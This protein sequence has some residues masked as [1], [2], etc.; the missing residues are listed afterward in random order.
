M[1]L[2]TA[3][4]ARF[5]L[6]A[7]F[8]LSKG[9]IQMKRFLLIL[10]SAIP[11]SALGLLLYC[12]ETYNDAVHNES[13]FFICC[14]C[15]LGLIISTILWCCIRKRIGP[16]TVIWIISTIILVFVFY[17]GWKIPFCVVCDRVTAEDLG[18][19]I[20]W[21]QPEGYGH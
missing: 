11:L 1:A 18:F 5:A 2:W 6:R 9:T 13:G 17:V 10:Q 19:L 4:A 20:H 3:N 14:Y 21:I 12:L 16:A 7:L 8:E 15:V